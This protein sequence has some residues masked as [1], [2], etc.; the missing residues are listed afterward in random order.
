MY[1][2]A[3]LLEFEFSFFFS[4]SVQAQSM[5]VGN[6][7]SERLKIMLNEISELLN[8][9]AQT[10]EHCCESYVKVEEPQETI[11]GIGKSNY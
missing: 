7:P 4:I 1:I 11:R 2:F 6:V 10:L 8:L 3:S 5:P 9:V